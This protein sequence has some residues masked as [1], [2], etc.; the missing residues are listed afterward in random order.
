MFIGLAITKYY[1]DIVNARQHLHSIKLALYVSGIEDVQAYFSLRQLA[2][3]DDGWFIASRI[4]HRSG[5]YS[6]LPGAYCGN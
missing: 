1:K 2:Q 5:A 3:C 6:Q 4:Y